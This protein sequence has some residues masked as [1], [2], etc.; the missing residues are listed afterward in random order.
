MVRADVHLDDS[1]RSS[2]SSHGASVHSR[3]GIADDPDRIYSWND[4]LTE[5]D[6]EEL[7]QTIRKFQPNYKAASEQFVEHDLR[8]AVKKRLT[9]RNF[10]DSQLRPRDHE[11]VTSQHMNSRL[12]FGEQLRMW[13]REGAGGPTHVPRVMVV[14]GHAGQGGN[15]GL[16]GVYE[17]YPDDYCN[18]PVYQKLLEKGSV[19]Q[20]SE[21]HI[22]RRNR[23]TRRDFG[24]NS[25]RTRILLD[26]SDRWQVLPP[27]PACTGPLELQ[28]ARSAW[29]LY[30]Y[31]GFWLIG[32]RVGS[33]EAFARCPGSEEI[34]PSS[35]LSWEVWDIGRKRFVKSQ[36]LRAVK[37]G[38]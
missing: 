20:D 15:I 34:V 16:N 21:R 12:I 3:R 5:E 29:F 33:R 32:P 9:T 14:S 1:P 10:S 11:Y 19:R 37:G 23:A 17:R 27:L 24:V 13:E 31:E 4:E 36:G 35:L 7:R 25:P 8:T 6:F 18:R 2:H 38:S 30:F 22:G 28:A 26:R